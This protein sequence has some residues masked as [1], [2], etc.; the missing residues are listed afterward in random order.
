MSA[1][2]NP[3][4]P[5][6]GGPPVFPPQANLPVVL[7]NGVPT[8]YLF[9]W[10][11]AVFAAIMGS[12]GIIEVLSQIAP[13]S[14]IS[15][16]LAEAAIKD[17]V[18]RAYASP[19]PGGRFA[20][21]EARLAAMEAFFETPLPQ[22]QAWLDNPL[23]PMPRPERISPSAVLWTPVI[24]GTVTAGAQTYTAQAGFTV[25]VGPFVLVMFFVGLSALDAATAG[26]ITI[27]GLTELADGNPASPLMSGWFSRFDNV[28]LSAG[29]TQ[30]ANNIGFASSVINIIQSGSALGSLQLPVA[31]LSATSTFCGGLLYFR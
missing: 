16:A 1:T 26:N 31:G 17:G 21:L 6:S 19:D 3:Q 7:P 24:A 29:Y 9:Q 15:L 5:V 22:R 10:M 4:T 23:P 13:A 8:P 12:G 25:D 30:L 18:E 27:T 2:G 20:A 14:G 11:Q 28:T